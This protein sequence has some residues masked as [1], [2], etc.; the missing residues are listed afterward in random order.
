MLRHQFEE[1]RAERVQKYQVR[2][3]RL[4]RCTRRVRMRKAARMLACATACRSVAV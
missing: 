3:W 1:K 2:R 4:P